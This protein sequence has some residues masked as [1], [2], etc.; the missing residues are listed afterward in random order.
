VDEPLTGEAACRVAGAAEEPKVDIKDYILIGG[1]LLIA[2]VVAH[3]FWIAWRTRQEPLR[4]DI[5][6]DL[7]PEDMDELERLRGELPN[8][9]ARVVSPGLPRP[10]QDALALEDPAPLLLEPTE[11]PPA[12][13]RKT[14]RTEPV[15]TTQSPVRNRQT[16][17]ADPMPLASPPQDGE[18]EEAADPT[19]AS[20]ATEDATTQATV[21]EV[22]LPQ[23]PIIAEEPVRGEGQRATGR[24]S[25]ER[26]VE[27]TVAEPPAV[28]ELIVMNVLAAT[29]GDFTGD[30]LYAILRG[31]GLKFGEMNIFH[32]V[33]P[34]TKMT[35]YSVAN[36]VEPGTF[37]M[38]D[39]EAFRAPGLCFFLQLPG[40]EH[41]SEVFEDMLAVAR[42]VVARLGGELKDEHMN[43]MTPQTVAHYRQR[44]AEF[45]RRRMSRRA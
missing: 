39:M 17:E 45:S 30:A 15:L 42:E 2:T 16:P 38:A 4:I 37:D 5:Q 32:R 6:P 1:G 11:G 31:R 24:K 40:P 27:K 34:L 18:L 8:G 12:A 20:A 13:E 14:R 41:P 29:S 22:V 3:G 43:V 7:I 25:A 23:A 35:H 19:A 33:E 28:E 36:V 9:G 44:I 26:A 21:A 10:Q